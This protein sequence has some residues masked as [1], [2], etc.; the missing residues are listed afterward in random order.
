MGLAPASPA[1]HTTASHTFE[2]RITWPPAYTHSWYS[3]QICVPVVFRAMD[4]GML[5]IS[6][7]PPDFVLGVGSGSSIFLLSICRRFQ[8]NVDARCPGSCIEARFVVPV[9]QDC[10]R[11]MHTQKDL[12]RRFICVFGLWTNFPPSAKGGAFALSILELCSPEV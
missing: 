5:M 10:N 8:Q 12:F 7:I 6:K 4:E 9:S 11:L 1:C 2:N 3:G